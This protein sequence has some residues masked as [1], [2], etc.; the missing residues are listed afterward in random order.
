MR[1]VSEDEALWR[2]MCAG[3]LRLAPRGDV[4]EFVAGVS[5]LTGIVKRQTES[6]EVGQLQAAD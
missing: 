3:S 1:M 2:R 6:F 5:G 4:A